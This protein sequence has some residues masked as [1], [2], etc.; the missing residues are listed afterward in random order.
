MTCR[1]KKNQLAGSVTIPMYGRKDLSDTV[2]NAT[3]VSWEVET[4]RTRALT[5]VRILHL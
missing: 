3:T 4:S 5:P 1:V 2:C